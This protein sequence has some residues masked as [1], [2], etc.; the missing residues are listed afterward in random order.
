MIQNWFK[1]DSSWFKI[2]SNLI[3]T[4]FKIDSNLIQNQNLFKRF[5]KRSKKW[6]SSVSWVLSTRDTK[7]VQKCFKHDS[8]IIQMCFLMWLFGPWIS[9]V[10]SRGLSFK[11]ISNL[12][13]RQIFLCWKNAYGIQLHLC[14]NFKETETQWNFFFK[15]SFPS[16]SVHLWLISQVDFTNGKTKI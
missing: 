15:Y 9:I 12:L 6:V 11:R 8:K 10:L 5:S 2:D 13:N 16:L 3:Q 7:L 14:S 4:W 1:I